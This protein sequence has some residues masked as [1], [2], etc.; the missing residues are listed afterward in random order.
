MKTAHGGLRYLKNFEIGLVRESLRE[1]RVLCNIAPGLVAP[2]PIVLPEPGLVAGLAVGALG[3]GVAG[4][5]R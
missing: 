5:R 2:F 1:R 3:L 4:R